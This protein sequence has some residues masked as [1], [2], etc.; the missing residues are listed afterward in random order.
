MAETLTYDNQTPAEVA[1]EAGQLTP[2]E[3]DSLQVGESIQEA[4]ETMLAGKYKDA[5]EL[6][7]AYIELQQKLGEKSGG[8]SQEQSSDEPQ[9]EAKSDEETEGASPEDYAIFDDFWEQ[10]SS[11]E[12]NIDQALLG[13]LA[14]MN[15]QQ[16]AQKFLQW[17]AD[18][19]TKYMPKPPDMTD[20]DVQELKAVAGG[21]QNYNNMLRWAKS[22]LSEQEIAMFDTVM[23]R[24]DTISAFFAIN[25]LAQ[26]YNDGVGYE[27]KML[28]GNAAKDR[29]DAFRSQAELVRAMSDSRYENDP[30][31]RQ[32][33]MEKLDRSNLNF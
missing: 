15:T 17:R 11:E 31:Y 14:G 22:N 2:D 25:S 23:G 24:G 12:G 5:Q 21:E 18:A 7:K 28:T 26:R 3:Q 29:V 32:D 16:M 6:E 20:K 10:A 30:A 1:G 27:G 8:E 33:I 4:Q 19:E 13:K 9:A